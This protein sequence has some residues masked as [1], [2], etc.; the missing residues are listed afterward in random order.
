MRIKTLLLTAVLSVA[1]AASSMADVFSVNVVGYVNKVYPI[2]LSMIN[3]PLSNSNNTVAQIFPNPPGFT[4]IYKFSPVSGYSPAN[5]FLFG[6][7]TDPAMVLAPGEGAFI[8]FAEAYTNTYVGEVLTGTRTNTISTGLNMLGSKV[9][10]A[11]GLQ[12]TLGLTP[13]GFDI[14]YK[15]DAG[16]QNYGAANT[17][18]FGN[19]ANGDPQIEVAEGF[20]Y[21]NQNGQNDWVRTFNPNTP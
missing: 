19:W 12:G 16:I 7:W 13:G 20:F 4:Q 6:N 5:T 11:G 18:L 3:N 2:G 1:A 15:Y 8:N 14:V 10:Q 21:L 9:P 17:F